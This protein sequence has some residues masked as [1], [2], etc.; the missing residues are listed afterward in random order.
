MDRTIELV[1]RGCAGPDRFAL[2]S[3]DASNNTWSRSSVM[4]NPSLQPTPFSSLR[5]KTGAA[6]LS[7]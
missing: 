1:E 6:E 4:P 2:R 7:R 5:S 3:P